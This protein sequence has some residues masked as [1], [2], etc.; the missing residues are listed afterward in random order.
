LKQ[1]KYNFL[2]EKMKNRIQTSV[3]IASILLLISCGSEKAPVSEMATISLDLLQEEAPKHVNQ[4][5]KISGIADHVCKHGG[6]KILLVSNENNVHVFSKERFDENLVGQELIITGI[7][8]ENIIDESTF[9]KWEEDA[10]TIED[11]A[12]KISSLEYVTV[13][14]D[15]LKASG[16]DYFSDY[17][18]DYISHQITE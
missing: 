8:G 14:R 18:V 4:T 15:S 2:G 9:Q 13:M 1:N 16:K 6:K 5:I 12:S 17:Y 10:N 11:H 7:L 3:M